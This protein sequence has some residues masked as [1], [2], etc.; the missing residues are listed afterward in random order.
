MEKRFLLPIAQK[1]RDQ[2]RRCDLVVLLNWRLELWLRS[3]FFGE[4]LQKQELSFKMV[5]EMLH[6]YYLSIIIFMFSRAEEIH[7]VCARKSLNNKLDEE[8]RLDGFSVKKISVISPYQCADACLRDTRCK[9]FN[10]ER[11]LHSGDKKFCEL[12][13]AKWNDDNDANQNKEWDYYGLDHEGLQE[14]S[15]NIVF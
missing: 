5:I 7:A 14:V 15:R 11:K 1:V 10:V 2:K 12:N 6:L 9:S 13:D 3:G 8:T 4:R